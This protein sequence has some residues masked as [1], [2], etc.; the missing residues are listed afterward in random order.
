MALFH[1]PAH[2]TARVAL[3][4][5]IPHI[6]RAS[7]GKLSILYSLSQMFTRRHRLMPL[8]LRRTTLSHS[9]T[10]LRQATIQGGL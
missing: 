10:I 2:N 3:Q 6:L 4:P 8:R 9:N 5:A 7:G 1:A